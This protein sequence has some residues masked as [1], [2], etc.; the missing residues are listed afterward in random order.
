[1]QSIMGANSVMSCGPQM[2]A[3]KESKFKNQSM[4]EKAK[5]I[6][7][8]ITKLSE[9]NMR[10]EQGESVMVQPCLGESVMVQPCLFEEIMI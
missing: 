2:L 3:L 7:N 4:I 5:E 8:E 9:G 6:E 10:R 1:M